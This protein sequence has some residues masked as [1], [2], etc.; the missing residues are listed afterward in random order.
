M[1]D[2][3]HSASGFDGRLADGMEGQG[4][5]GG[6]RELKTELDKLP[7]AAGVRQQDDG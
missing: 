6:W 7:P 2:D 1:C 4:S 3:R 5:V